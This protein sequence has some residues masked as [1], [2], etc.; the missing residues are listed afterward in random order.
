RAHASTA[1]GV[2]GIIGIW[3]VTR[4]PRWP[5]RPFS[6]FATRFTSRHRSWYVRTR[7]SPGSPSQTIAALFRRGPPRCRSRQFAETLSRPPTNHFAKGGSQSRT[8][9][10]G[11][12]QSRVAA[13]RAQ[14]AS[15][16]FPASTRKESSR[17]AASFRKP[18]GGG[19]CSF[20]L[21]RLSIVALETTTPDHPRSDPSPADDGGRAIAG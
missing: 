8:L 3:V 18:A 5:P 6:T 15:G 1:I 4:S 20:S 12:I 7:R 17:T 14:K 11:A 9:D 2:P 16:S 19:Y 13:I 21:S 10:Q